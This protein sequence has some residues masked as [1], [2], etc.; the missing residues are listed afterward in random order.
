MPYIFREVEKRLN[1]IT[2][3]ATIYWSYMISFNSHNNH[4]CVQ[5]LMFREIKNISKVIQLELHIA[6]TQTLDLDTN[7]HVCGLLNE[8]NSCT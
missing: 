2:G 4:N 7:V 5:E 1:N 8:T 3:R 6:Q